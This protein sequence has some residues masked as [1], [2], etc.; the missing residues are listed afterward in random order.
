MARQRGPNNNQ[1]DRS[2]RYDVALQTSVRHDVAFEVEEHVGENAE[3]RQERK[4]EQARAREQQLWEV[5]LAR[6]AHEEQ[7][8]VNQALERCQLGQHNKEEEW[9]EEEY[10]SE[11]RGEYDNSTM[12][13]SFNYHIEYLLSPLLIKQQ[14]GSK[15]VEACVLLKTGS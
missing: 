7:F 2:A 9:Q 3:E 6:Q 1:I 12:G 5:A 13:K 14:S 15:N 4:E 8:A 11:I 10:H